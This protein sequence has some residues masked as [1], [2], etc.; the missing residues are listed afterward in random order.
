MRDQ[1]VDELCHI[2]VLIG[3]DAQPDFLEERQRTL[4]SLAYRVVASNDQYA[5]AMEGHQTGLFCKEMLKS[6]VRGDSFC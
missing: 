2:L 6:I 5:V 4:T 1:K 3:I